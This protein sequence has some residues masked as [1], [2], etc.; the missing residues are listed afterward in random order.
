MEGLRTTITMAGTVERTW[1]FDNPND[2]FA[3]HIDDATEDDKRVK[4]WKGHV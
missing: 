4:N 1:A 3:F 2:P